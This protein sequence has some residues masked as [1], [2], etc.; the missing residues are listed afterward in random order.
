MKH[1]FGR[2][3]KEKARTPAPRWRTKEKNLASVNLM[4]AN[5]FNQ[6]EWQLTW[7]G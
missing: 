6:R 7:A 3:R 5:Q 4:I 1:G 2:E